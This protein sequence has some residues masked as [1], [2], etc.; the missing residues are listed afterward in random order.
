MKRQIELNDE[1]IDIDI[2]EQ[3][4]RFV[5]FNLD[6]TEYAVNL[7][8]VEDY[9]Y[10]LAYNSGNTTVV[11][12]DAHFVVDGVEFAIN[13]PRRSR[14]KGKSADHGQMTS[15]MPGKILKIF[16]KEGQEVIPGTPILVMEA[17]KMEHTIKSS[18]IGKVEKIHFK[19]GDQVQGGVELV[20]LC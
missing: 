12:V 14:S 4:A 7:G 6:G 5:L 17:M 13:A 3:N 11:A 10:N 15:P 1:L 18:K 9:K 20:K 2:L 16:V 19:E 8:N